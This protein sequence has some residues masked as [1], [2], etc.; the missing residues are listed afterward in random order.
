MGRTYIRGQVE[1]ISHMYTFLY[2]LVRLP[3]FLKL[4]S[5]DLRCLETFRGYKTILQT[6]DKEPRTEETLLSV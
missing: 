4:V 1:R 5:K 3:R 2:P 6:E